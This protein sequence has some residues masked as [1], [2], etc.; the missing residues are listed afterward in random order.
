MYYTAN[1][2]KINVCNS[3][4]TIDWETI[5]NSLVAYLLCFLLVTLFLLKWFIC[6]ACIYKIIINYYHYKALCETAFFYML[7]KIIIINFN[8]C[9]AVESSSRF[10]F[11]LLIHCFF[12]VDTFLMVLSCAICQLG[13]PPVKKIFFFFR[14][15]GQQ[16]Y[17]T[18][19]PKK[20]YKRVDE[21]HSLKGQ[22]IKLIKI[23]YIGLHYFYFVSLF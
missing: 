12:Y 16:C 4:F 13:R 20:C 19:E 9:N 7:I 6:D 8:L 18:Y 17:A 1:W 5:L 10:Y 22:C 23:K 3:N 14:R 15:T 2:L 21:N 11:L